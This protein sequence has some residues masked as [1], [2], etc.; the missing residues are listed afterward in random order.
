MAPA[1]RVHKNTLF[2]TCARGY[3]RLTD[4]RVFFLLMP[5]THE[6]PSSVSKPRGYIKKQLINRTE[7]CLSFEFINGLMKC[8]QMTNTKRNK[9]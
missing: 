4:S 6:Y 8:Q 9:N 5:A 2:I 7:H 3:L 1:G